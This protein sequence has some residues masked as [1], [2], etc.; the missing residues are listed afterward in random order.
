[1]RIR[2]C[3]W[4]IPWEGRC[5]GTRAFLR[6]CSS[7]SQCHSLLGRMSWDV[8]GKRAWEFPGEEKYTEKT[9]IGWKCH[10]SIFKTLQHSGCA[11]KRMVPWSVW[12]RRDGITS[13]WEEIPSNLS[14]F[15]TG[16]DPAGSSG[17]LRLEWSRPEGNQQREGHSFA[18]ILPAG[19]PGG[20]EKSRSV[21][22]WES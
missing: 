13:T 6:I 8:H 3:C 11:W 7:S 4:I 19:I 12:D 21:F 16:R 2:K 15:P 17:S 1:M 5:W 20:A 22:R 9:G 14:C 10:S 18:G